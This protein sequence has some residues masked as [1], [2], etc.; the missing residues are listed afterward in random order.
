[1]L[2][3][4]LV[5]YVHCTRNSKDDKQAKTKV[6]VFI[7][8]CEEYL[9]VIMNQNN[10]EV[11]VVREDHDDVVASLSPKWRGCGSRQIFSATNDNDNSKRRPKQFKILSKCGGRR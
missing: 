2:Y 3:M 8:A 10:R 9:L 4:C 7:A 1:M 5:G 6:V 11:G